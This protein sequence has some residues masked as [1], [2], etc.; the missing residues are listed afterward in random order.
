MQYYRTLHK[1]GY[2]FLYLNR[3]NKITTTA[4]GQHVPGF[5]PLTLVGKY[6]R[7]ERIIV[8]LQQAISKISIARAS[9][10]DQTHGLYYGNTRNFFHYH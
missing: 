9:G 8:I 3:S 5:C 6:R 10:G 1:M 7:H 2:Y 4:S